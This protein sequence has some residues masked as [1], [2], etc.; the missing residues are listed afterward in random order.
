MADTSKR[1]SAAEAAEHPWLGDAE[2]VVAS[3]AQRHRDFL[4]TEEGQ[5]RGEVAPNVE[6]VS[7]G[8]GELR[9]RHFLQG[10]LR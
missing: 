8:L 10:L 2:D 9:R 6:E 4:A 1:L 5:G 7:C 3:R